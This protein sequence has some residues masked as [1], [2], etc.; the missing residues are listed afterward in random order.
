MKKIILTGTLAVAAL[1]SITSCENDSNDNAQPKRSELYVTSGANG[2]VT[3]YDFASASAQTTTFTTLSTSNEGVVYD[4]AKDELLVASRSN[5]NVGI[6]TNIVSQ[7]M[8][9]TQ[10]IVGTTSSVN[11]DSPR[12]MATNGTIVVVADNAANNLVIY[13]RTSTGLSYR[14]TVSVGF[15]LWGIEFIGNDLYAVVDL[16]GDLA[17]FTNFPVNTANAAVQAS[18]R[19]TVAGIVRTHGLT[20]DATDD[21]MVMTDVGS[22][23]SPTDGAFHLIPN[24]RTLFASVANGGTIALSSQTRVAGAATLLG[25]PVAVDYDT[26]TNTVFIAE[27]ANGGGRV[28]SYS[29]IGAGGNITPVINNMLAGANALYL[30]KN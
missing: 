12:A 8:G 1:L 5:D 17:V 9:T 14:N 27:A 19:I 26:A 16:S 25:N 30:Y 28:L 2:N 23:A 4:G 22:A 24:F 29:N 3:V 20:Y 18:K 6:Y 13:N 11:L 10:A 15:P 21:L 7:L